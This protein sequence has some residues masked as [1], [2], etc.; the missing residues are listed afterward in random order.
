MPPLNSREY[1]TPLLNDLVELAQGSIHLSAMRRI[2]PGAR[3]RAG[4]PLSHPIAGADQE[5]VGREQTAERLSLSP[6]A[7]P[8]LVL[9]G[10]CHTVDRRLCSVHPIAQ[11]QDTGSVLLLLAGREG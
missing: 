11:C 4:R 10:H 1:L 8:D 9:G 7:L 3:R 5:I 6:E 2:A